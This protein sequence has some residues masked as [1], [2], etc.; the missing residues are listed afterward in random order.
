[1]KNKGLIKTGVLLIGLSVILHYI[2]FLVFKDMH[3]IM[4]F[5]IADIAFIPLEVFFVTVVLD[6]MIEKREK[7]HLIEKLNMLVGLFY[8]QLGLN[9]FRQFIEADESI[10]KLSSN[11][12]VNASSKIDDFKSTYEFLKSHDHHINV[13]KI[14][15]VKL[16]DAIN[17][18]KDL[19]VSLIA[20][21]SLLEHESFSELLMSI[22]HLQEELA[23]RE[24]SSDKSKMNK[25]DLEHL[26]VDCVRAYKNISL[27]WLKYIQHLKVNYPYLYVTALIKNPYDFRNTDEIEKEVFKKLMEEK[28]RE[29][30]LNK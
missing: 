15:F 10:V 23:M 21:P 30:K 24:I 17:D 8:S 22:F 28:N 6:K 25:H 12:K 5:L 20:N 29:E 27:E 14:N 1:M 13:E 26:T 16:N 2:H 19:L 18:S 4:V 3:H 9:V 7:M 11:C